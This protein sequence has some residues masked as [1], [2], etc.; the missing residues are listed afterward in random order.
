MINIV[1]DSAGRVIPEGEE[2]SYNTEIVSTFGINDFTK[3]IVNIPV[4]YRFKW[5]VAH[6]PLAKFVQLNG[7]KIKHTICDEFSLAGHLFIECFGICFIEMEYLGV[8]A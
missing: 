6:W 8:K 4:G 2:K 1:T 5:D 3:E 7:E